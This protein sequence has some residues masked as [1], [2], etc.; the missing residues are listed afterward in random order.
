MKYFALIDDLFTFNYLMTEEV[1][2][3]LPTEMLDN[4]EDV[5][6]SSII[7]SELDPAMESHLRNERNVKLY[8]NIIRR[9]DKNSA[10]VI[11]DVNDIF[12]LIDKTNK[13]KPEIDILITNVL[14]GSRLVDHPD[15]TQTGLPI[16]IPNGWPYNIGKIGN[17]QIVVD[18]YIKYDDTNML[19]Y[20]KK[21]IRVAAYIKSAD[22]E[23]QGLEQTRLVS[24]ICA[25]ISNKIP[26]DIIEVKVPTESL[27]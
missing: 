16:D 4:V 20:S 26:V 6:V 21:D 18:P 1:L 8:F 23:Y 14:L 5:I 15:Y 10:L 17:I 24:T 13:Q 2:N 22:V 25:Y 7:T 9:L 3:D 19:L 12:T 11:E 27:I